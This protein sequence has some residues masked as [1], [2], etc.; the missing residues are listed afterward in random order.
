MVRLND[1]FDI[2]EFAANPDTF[3]ERL[4]HTGSPEVLT[5]NGQE[6]VVVQDA[7]TY[8][9]LLDAVERIEAIEGIRRGLAE[10]EQGKGRPFREVI[11][12]LGR[13]FEGTGDR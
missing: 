1:T 3:V 11:E 13:R 10:L 6:A 12:E 4:R 5:V 2:N 9:K 8:R 7:K